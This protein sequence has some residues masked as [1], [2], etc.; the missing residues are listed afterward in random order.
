MKDFADTVATIF[1]YYGKMVGFGVFLDAVADVTQVDA[2]FDHFHA[3]SHAFAAD[4]AQ[5]LG[6]NGRLA[7]EK[8]LTGI[9]VV[10]VFDDGDVN[11]DDVTIFKLFG[12]GNAMADLII[13]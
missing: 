13:H 10:A 8:H 12:A 6:E 5:T 1:P 7:D 2:G 9:T 11:V 4:T 3:Q